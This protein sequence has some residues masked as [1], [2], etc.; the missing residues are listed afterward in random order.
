MENNLSLFILSSLCMFM[1]ILISSAFSFDLFIHI[2]NSFAFKAVAQVDD[3]KSKLEKLSK[4]FQAVNKKWEK[5][6]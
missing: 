4:D 3:D 5:I 2:N 6:F 1:F